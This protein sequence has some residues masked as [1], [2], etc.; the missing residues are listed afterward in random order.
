MDYSAKQL[1]PA[2]YSIFAQTAYP[3]TPLLN[4]SF[5]VIFNP[6]DHSMLL[7]PVFEFSLNQNVYLLASS[8]FFLGNDLTEWGD[9]GQFYY[10]R[11]K[12]NY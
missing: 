3:I 6:T 11:I 8:Q 9:Y 1:S 4:A 2:R 10:L 5:S 12:W 7:S